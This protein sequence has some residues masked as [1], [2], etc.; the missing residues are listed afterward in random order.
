MTVDRFEGDFAVIVAD[1]GT[2]FNIPRGTLCS[3]AKEGDVIK[4]TVDFDKTNEKK[5]AIK[6]KMDS[7]F[8]D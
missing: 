2:V 4:I 3:S 7:L 8:R 5:E 6:K 1:D